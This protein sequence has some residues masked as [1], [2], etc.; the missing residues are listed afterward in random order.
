MIV[1]ASQL[2]ITGCAMSVPE[3]PI[4]YVPQENVQSVKDASTVAVETKVEDLQPSESVNRLGFVLKDRDEMRFRV[5]DAADTLKSATETELNARGFKVGAGGAVIT[6]QV[7][8][9]EANY[10]GSD[11]GLVTTVR[12]SLFM[13]V[14]VQTQ[15]GKVLFSKDI[16]DRAAPVSGM[17]M[18]HPATQELQESLEEAFKG[19]F[20]DPAFTAAI[21][22]T[23]LQPPPLPAKPVTP[24]RIAGA[25]A[26]MSRR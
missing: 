2:L 24:A 6:I 16:E 26:T 20:D 25:F 7:I 13:R 22:A 14:Q 3:R 4:T 15:A 18:M 1:V 17:F 23:R 21:L 5:K 10:E 12:G 19:L 11:M 8:R 9:F